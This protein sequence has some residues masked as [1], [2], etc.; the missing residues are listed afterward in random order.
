MRDH[1]MRAACVHV[2]ADAAVSILAIF[3]LLLGRLLGWDFMD[4]VMGIIGALVI[5]NWAY[6]LIRDTSGVLLDMSADNATA[7]ELRRMIES[8]GDH[9]SDLTPKPPHHGQTAA[10]RILAQASP[11]I[12]ENGRAIDTASVMGSLPYW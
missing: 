7:A 6:G 2:A 5:A 10:R 12:E 8:G 11:L 4:P 1:N 9:L 3:G